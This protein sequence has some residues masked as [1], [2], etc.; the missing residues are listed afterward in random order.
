MR[1]AH[2]STQEQSIAGEDSAD[3]QHPGHER[4]HGHRKPPQTFDPGDIFEVLMM[5][6]EAEGLSI[7]LHELSVVNRMMIVRDFTAE[8]RHDEDLFARSPS[9]RC[10]ITGEPFRVAIAR[11]AIDDHDGVPAAGATRMRL[12]SR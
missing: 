6:R 9:S 3:K 7:R 2:S 11:V 10:Q 8:Q 5:S 12:T 1:L 4:Q